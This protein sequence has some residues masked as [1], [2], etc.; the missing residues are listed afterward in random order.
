MVQKG[1]ILGKSILVFVTVG[2]TPF[3]FNRLFKA[4]DEAL[5]ELKKP[6][7]LIVQQGE[8]NY[9]WQYK[10]VKTYKYLRPDR[11]IYYIK[12]ADKIITH[13]GPGSLF[14]IFKYTKIIPFILARSS[15]FKEHVNDHQIE[16]TKFIKKNF[17]KDNN[18]FIDNLLSNISL[19]LK[20]YLQKKFF[21]NFYLMRNP[22]DYLIK[23]L[24]KYLK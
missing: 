7:K 15:V 18:V 16:F 5:L 10:N 9:Q 6:I 11:M 2:T 17:L 23:K 1:K 22:S 13:A 20:S 12:K 19:K 24:N 4:I 3:Q 21:I 14:L 8:S